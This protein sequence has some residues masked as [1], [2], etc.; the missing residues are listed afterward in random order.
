MAAPVQPQ[1]FLLEIQLLDLGPRRHVGEQ[2]RRRPCG[3]LVT[4]EQIEVALTEFLVPLRAS[5]VLAGA[6]NARE[7]PRADGWSGS[8]KYRGRASANQC[9]ARAGFHERLEDALVGDTE[10]EDFA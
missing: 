1:G 8:P 6:V 9:V 7:Q 2:N 10:V 3:S 5:S 4:P